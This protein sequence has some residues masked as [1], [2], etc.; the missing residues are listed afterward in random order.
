M[1]ESR[2]KDKEKLKK[3]KKLKKNKLK[4]IVKKLFLKSFYFKVNLPLA[5]TA[6]KVS[7]PA[8]LAVKL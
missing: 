3:L 5:L 8:Y 2:K 7:S 1:P 4:R 6:L